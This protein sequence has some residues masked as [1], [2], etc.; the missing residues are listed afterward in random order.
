MSKFKLEFEP[1]YDFHLIAISCH[2][3][4]FKLAWSISKGLDCSLEK[5]EDL[6]AP[7][8]QKGSIYGSFTYYFCESDGGHYAYHLLANKS[9]EGLL[10][11]EQKQADFFFAITGA[12]NRLDTADILQKIKAQSVVLTAY[13]IDPIS[14]KSKD[15]FILE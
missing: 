15:K 13:S 5:I 11:P 12:H 10:A 2:Q 3:K 8:D 1:D 4:D 7:I 9:N 14:L 6:E